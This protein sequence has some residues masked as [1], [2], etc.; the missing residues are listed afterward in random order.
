MRR[1]TSPQ[2]FC[3]LVTFVVLAVLAGALMKM[4]EGGPTRVVHV[5]TE[6]GR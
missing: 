2:T 3:L 5:N 1:P 6:A 4:P